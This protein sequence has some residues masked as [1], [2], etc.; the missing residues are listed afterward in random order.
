MPYSFSSP[1]LPPGFTIAEDRLLIDASAPPFSGTLTLVLT[2]GM[3]TVSK[4]VVVNHQGATLNPMAQHLVA[5]FSARSISGGMTP[6]DILTMQAIGRRTIT[7]R[8]VEVSMI[9]LRS[10]RN[11]MGG[12][13]VSSSVSET[14][15]TQ[16]VV[17]GYNFDVEWW[18]STGDVTLEWAN[19]FEIYAYTTVPAA[20]ASNVNCSNQSMRSALLSALRTH[21]NHPQISYAIVSCRDGSLEGGLYGADYF[22]LKN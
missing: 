12:V 18:D 3:T 15:E 5:T 11:I 20:L 16:I 2:D 21:Y 14:G 13:A 9:Q 17:G 1:D 10:Q 7:G 4:V 19:T 8:T 6:L 22:F